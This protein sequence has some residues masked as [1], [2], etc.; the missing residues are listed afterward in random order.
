M[1][2][3]S[4]RIYQFGLLC[5]AGCFLGAQA[6]AAERPIFLNIDDPRGFDKAMLESDWMLTFHIAAKDEKAG[7]Y[8]VIPPSGGD[9]FKSFIV[10]DPDGCLDLT[11]ADP[12][13]AGFPVEFCAGGPDETLLRYELEELDRPGRG[14]FG[15]CV[16]E[17]RDRLVDTALSDIE[18]GLVSIQDSN[19]VFVD[20]ALGDPTTVSAAVVGPDTGGTATGFGEP[21]DCYG[22]GADDDISSLVVMVNIG[23]AR[24]FDTQMNYDNTRIRNMAGFLSHTHTELVGRNGRSALVGEMRITRGMMEPITLIDIN[25]EIFQSSPDVVDP[26]LRRKI[27]DGP[28]ETF[29][30]SGSFSPAEMVAEIHKLLPGEYEVEI[31]AVIVDGQAP[32][33]IDDNS[34]NGKITAWD[35]TRGPSPYTLLS[36]ESVRRFTVFQREVL[37]TE[38]QVF[39]C[40]RL[41]SLKYA[42]LDGNGIS[43]FC[44]DGDGSSRSALRPLR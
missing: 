28:I 14:D 9:R 40:P 29:A 6:A 43:G 10:E 31:R 23:A 30:L 35:L 15:A 5:V 13:L 3:L 25:A 2:R 39:E 19:K 33:F 4:C 44:D 32:D 42:D 16:G 11:G 21:F 17:V 37:I 24:I 22:Y 12:S 7:F 18:T 8:D 1:N 20:L 34:G 26:V 36:N 38:G 41:T 27:D